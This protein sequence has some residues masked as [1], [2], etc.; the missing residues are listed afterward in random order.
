MAKE[1][2]PTFTHEIRLK[3][4]QY[5]TRKVMIKFRA[6]RELYNTVLGEMLKRNQQMLND[7]RYQEACKAYRKDKSNKEN[8]RTFDALQAEYK[9]NKGNF[10]TLA[11]SI[12][13][14][15]YMSNH[16]DAHT[17]QVISDR[18]YRAYIEW[19]MGKRG[20]PRFKSWKYG[21]RSIQG[22]ANSCVYM[23]PK[24]KI[25][26]GK[27]LFDVCY[28]KK[29]TYGV[30]AHALNSPIKFCRIVHR[31]I[32]GKDVF[33]VQLILEGTA[34]VKS[35]HIVKKGVK[36]GLDIG[37]STIAAVSKDKALL[38]PLCQSLEPINKALKR[39]QRK[40]NRSQRSSNPKNYHEDRWVKKNKHPTLKK[41]AVKKGAKRW[42]FSK[43][44]QKDLASLKELHRKQKDTRQFLHNTLANEVIALGNHLHIEKNSYK[45]W[46]KGWF[47]KTIGFR[48]PSNFVQTLQRKALK[49]GGEA[50]DI[51][52]WQAKL[53]QSCHVCHGFHKKTLKERTHTCHGKPIAQRDLYS[54]LLALYYDEDKIN[55]LQ[56]S[57]HWDSL[58][59][60]LK[61]AVLVLEKSQIS[62]AWVPECLI[63][64]QIEKRDSIQTSY[65]IKSKGCSEFEQPTFS[66][67]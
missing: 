6:L 39:V 30:Q 53:S 5:Q 22:K 33:Y 44:Y 55:Y 28:D 47:G 43:T 8:R 51:N 20:K 2:S 19:R 17:P 21:I 52:A 35:N 49:T 14:K 34:L 64:R 7:T 66:Q 1:Y 36:V 23:T 24:G 62:G 18:A 46:Q 29:D 37:V 31:P 45:A 61:D 65:P 57:E 16:L 60:V 40:M 4:N 42:M 12:K 48:A 54:A 58:D 67:R 41:G 10:Q 3:T 15:T 26:W 25:K 50:R 11:T 38:I 63:P 59:T 9:L 13:N 27:L 56:V 32:K